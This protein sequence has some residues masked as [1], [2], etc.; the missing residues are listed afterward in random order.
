MIVVILSVFFLAFYFLGSKDVFFTIL[1]YSFFL[2]RP[3]LINL[4]ICVPPQLNYV[5]L[6]ISM[7]FVLSNFSKNQKLIIVFSLLYICFFGIKALTSPMPFID[8]LNTYKNCFITLGFSL[9]IIKDV[10][11][12]RCFSKRLYISLLCLLWFEI[13]I[14]WGQYFSP[15]FLSWF[16]VSYDWNGEQIGSGL[17]QEVMKTSH[18][19]I[20]TF[21]S[22]GAYATFL[23]MFIGIM[24]TVKVNEHQESKGTL[25]TIGACFITLL[26][27]GVRTPFLV[28]S[29]YALFLIY[30]YYRKKFIWAVAAVMLLLFV[31]VTSDIG[32]SES[33]LSRMQLGFSSIF[34]GNQEGVMET[35][36]GFSLLMLKYMFM[37]PLFGVSLHN[38]TGYMLPNGYT[39]EDISITDAQF[40]F[41][42][43]EIG[44]IGLII[45]LIPFTL[46]RIN[47][48]KPL[49]A[50]NHITVLVIAILLSVVDLGIFSADI[51]LLYSFSYAFF[52]N[53]INL[54]E[55]NSINTRNRFKLSG[56]NL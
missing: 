25:I 5:L 47:A 38:S 28:L 17:F 49:I 34:S 29:F 13:L 30:K 8:G 20:G 6:F 15:A 2:F 3:V 16:P 54:Y 35:T 44:I 39:M 46:S 4:G 19:M 23:A 9:E 21:M 14:G 32:D 26:F 36:L 45:Y 12:N 56:A 7:I 37:N 22:P 27:T 42:I 53:K 31:F 41:T 50:K 48:Y 10:Q 52:V 55:K 43:C 51:V 33:S 24:M 40:F 11:T 1:I 18:A